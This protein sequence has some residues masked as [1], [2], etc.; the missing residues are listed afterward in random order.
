MFLVN[1]IIPNGQFVVFQDSIRIGTRDMATTGTKVT[2][3]TTATMATTTKA[4]VAMIT[5]VTT[6]ITADMV[7]TA[8]CNLFGEGTLRKQRVCMDN[9]TMD[10]FLFNLID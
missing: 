3:T 6:T 8:V 9:L 5:L 7:T 10:F 1:S 4:T 2:A